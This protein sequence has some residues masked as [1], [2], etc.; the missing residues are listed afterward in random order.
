MRAVPPDLVVTSRGGVPLTAHPPASTAHT[1][2]PAE[3]F[4]Y[5]E[6]DAIRIF[7]FFGI[8]SYHVLPREMSVYTNHHIPSELASLLVNVIKACSC[9]L[10][11]FFI[12]SAFLI[13]ELLLRERELKGRVDL[14]TF[15][16]RRLLRIWPLYFFVIALVGLISLF[17]RT[18]VI[19]WAYALSFFLFAG[20]WMM[21]LRGLPR[22]IAIVPLWSVSFEEQFYLLWPLV[23]RRATKKTIGGIAIGLL[24][25]A[26]L[27]RAFLLLKHQS[28]DSIWYN[29]FARLDSIVC[30]ILLAL[31]FHGKATLRVGRVVRLALLLLGASAWMVVGEYCG[32]LDEAPRLY[33]GLLGYPLMSLG[34]VAIFLA[35]LG[36]RTHAEL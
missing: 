36:S 25:V 33:G 2:R 14:K 8:W 13:T 35:V 20:N 3:R 15:Y 32:L 28:G 16:I 7:L 5:P 6:L 10:D 27:A 4:Y 30:G 9:S 22:A 1:H 17:D 12:L 26:S 29:T 18:Q 21:A 23:L 24:M 31:I 11:V 34:G 19:G